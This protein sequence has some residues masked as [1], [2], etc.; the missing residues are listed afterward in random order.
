M[1][2]AEQ[3]HTLLPRLKEAL[4][5]EAAGVSDTVLLKFLLWKSDAPDPV[6]R[7]VGRFRDHVKWRQE[8]PY[9]FDTTPLLASQDPELKRILESE[10]M[11]APEGM[12]DKAGNV[13][14]VGRLRNNDMNDGRTPEGVARHALYTIDRVLERKEALENGV[15]I[16]HDLTGLGRKNLHTGIPQLIMRA[17]IGNFPLKIKGIYIFNAPLFFWGFFKVMSVMFPAKLR[18]RTHFLKKLEDVYE[19]IDQNQ[20]LLE[21][22]GSRQHDQTQWV[23]MQIE[24][25]I[26]GA[27]VSL[28]ECF[29]NE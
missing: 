28:K 5:V 29:R 15:V 27:V 10:V 24:R 4:G 25:E 8:S 7:A 17:I 18:Q 19:I 3:I 20:L 1:T 2:E 21:H 12:L 26:S 13:V 11:V 23:R 9:A 6:T 16:F 22:G 14:L